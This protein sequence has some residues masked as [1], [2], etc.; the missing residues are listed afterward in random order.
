[1]TKKKLSC[2]LSILL[3][4]SRG[5]NKLPG[6]FRRSQ[7]WIGGTRPGNALF[8]PP[9]VENLQDC[10]SSL[11]NFLHNDTL[12]TLIKA[13]LAHVQFET[14]HPFLDGNG[15]LGRLLIILL[16]IEGGIIAEPV[17][18]LS[19][20][21]KENRETY[22]S[23]LQTVR[24]EGRWENWLTFFLNGILTASQQAVQSAHQINHLFSQDLAK[25]R[26][27]GRARFSCEQVLEYLKHLPQVSIKNLSEELAIS[28]PTAR[29]AVNHLV[30]L[31]VLKEISGKKRDKLYIYRNYIELLEEGADP[32]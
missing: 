10:L 5:S 4:G 20:Y 14:I 15:R 18:Y 11:E 32:L 28:S 3:S 9:P 30:K 2:Y 25:I 23:L 19:L 7:N 13:G 12:P 16:L 6:E 22:Y 26:E 27:L 29:S 31:N 8:V 21:F 1:M 24:N 17:L